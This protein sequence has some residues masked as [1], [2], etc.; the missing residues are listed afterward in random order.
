M[1]GEPTALELAAWLDDVDRTADIGVDCDE[2]LSAAADTLRRQHAVIEARR[3]VGGV[4]VSGEAG[5]RKPQIGD[6]WLS[7]N[8]GKWVWALIDDME[9][10]RF[11]CDL[12]HESG[13]DDR[14]WA[15]VG[16]VVPVDH[17]G[18]EALAEDIADLRGAAF[19]CRSVGDDEAADGY[20]A[21]ADALADLLSLLAPSPG[22]PTP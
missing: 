10:D 18:I 16:R 21:R 1:S 6:V 2:W 12:A 20:E 3:L 22:G 9:R 17:P 7:T 19:D 14:T 8:D 15:L 5:A 13:N 11:I 4:P